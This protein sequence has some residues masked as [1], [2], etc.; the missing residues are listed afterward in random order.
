MAGYQF[1]VRNK[2]K[3]LPPCSLAKKKKVTKP[4][5]KKKP[6]YRGRGVL[7]RMG[8]IAF[9]TFLYIIYMH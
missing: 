8:G 5:P 6:C 9:D 7:T 3:V 4:C 2:N 1:Y